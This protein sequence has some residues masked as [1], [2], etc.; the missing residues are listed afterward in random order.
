MSL[1]KKCKKSWKI[2][3]QKLCNF[4][5]DFFGSYITGKQGVFNVH[6]NVGGIEYLSRENVYPSWGCYTG[7]FT[8]IYYY[9]VSNFHIKVLVLKIFDEHTI[10]YHIYTSVRECLQEATDMNFGEIKGYF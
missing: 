6:L 8:S 5:R 1:F 3:W 7:W 2:I 10:H 9:F 4:F